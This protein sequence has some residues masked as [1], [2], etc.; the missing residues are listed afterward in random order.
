VPLYV[1]TVI[2]GLVIVFITTSLDQPIGGYTFFTLPCWTLPKHLKRTHTS[3]TK[4]TGN[5]NGH[6]ATALK[7]QQGK[8]VPLWFWWINKSTAVGMAYSWLVLS[9]KNETNRSFSTPHH[10]QR[11]LTLLRR[12][13]STLVPSHRTCTFKTKTKPYAFRAHFLCYF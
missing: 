8:T 13:P 10:S 7:R 1:E 4:S 9:S 2:T 11:S 6:M 5:R 12:F 3:L